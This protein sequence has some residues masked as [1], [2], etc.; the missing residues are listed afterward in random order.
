MYTGRDPDFGTKYPEE[1]T[2]D[3][4]VLELADELLNQDYY[5]YLNNFYTSVA[6]VEELSSRKTDVGTVRLNKKGIPE[7]LKKMEL[8]RCKV[9]AVY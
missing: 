1:P 5:V 9:M 3:Q 8:K 7:M 6:F 4:I 2:T